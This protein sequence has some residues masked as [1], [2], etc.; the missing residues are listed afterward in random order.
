MH[1]SVKTK[2]K[3]ANVYSLIP[4]LW[5]QFENAQSYSMLSFTNICILPPVIFVWILSFIGERMNSKLRVNYRIYIF[6]NKHKQY[7]CKWTKMKIWV[8]TK[9]YT[10][11][12][13]RQ[14]IAIRKF[15]VVQPL[16]LSSLL[17]NPLRVSLFLKTYLIDDLLANTPLNQQCSS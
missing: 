3:G 15:I 1:S 11:R 10:E 13:E 2:T 4:L 14:W 5:P 8:L 7:L 17:E 6:C 9:S 12:V 16:W